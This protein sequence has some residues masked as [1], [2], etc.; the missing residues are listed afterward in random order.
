M[1]KIISLAISI[2]I[3]MSALASDVKVKTEVLDAFKTKFVN[4]K[5]VSWVIESGY[6]KVS[7]NN[8]GSWVCAYYEPNG[9]MA[10]IMRN[11]SSTELPYFLQNELK[12][13]FANY[14]ITGLFEVSNRDGY[15]YC[16]TLN[17]A[18]TKINM[19]SA[20]GTEWKLFRET[21]NEIIN[22]QD[23]WSGCTKK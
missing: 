17:N 22:M 16:V 21:K 4:A 19:F 11:I 3:A 6:Y 13:K 15:T 8:N 1:K 5:E 18:D 20:N 7:F 12:K 10:G 23:G 9:K 2:V 14:W